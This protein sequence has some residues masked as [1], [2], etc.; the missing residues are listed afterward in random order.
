MMA[1][2][3]TRALILGS[4]GHPVFEDVPVP[5]LRDDYILVKTRAVSINPAD[6]K[7][8]YTSFAGADAAGA[9]LGCDYAGIVEEVG[10]KVIK[11]LKRGDRVAGPVHG[12]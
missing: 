7:S 10:S 12:A 9:V 11:D 4:I 6:S 2:S 3:R 5:A 8:V 1:P